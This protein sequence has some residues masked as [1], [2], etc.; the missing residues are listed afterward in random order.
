[1]LE[2]EGKGEIKR[3]LG[4]S[5]DSPDNTDDTNN[6]EEPQNQTN[7]SSQ[8]EINNTY[9]EPKQGDDLDEYISQIINENPINEGSNNT[10]VTASVQQSNSWINWKI[11]L[12]VVILII[13]LNSL[14][15]L[16][17]STP[18]TTQ[19]NIENVTQVNENVEKQALPSTKIEPKPQEE[20]AP[21]VVEKLTEP[22]V[23]EPSKKVETVKTVSPPVI[24]NKYSDP[25]V[26]LSHIQNQLQSSFREYGST[27][28]VDCS[29]L[30]EPSGQVKKIKDEWNADIAYNFLSGISYNLPKFTDKQGNKI[31]LVVNF[32]GHSL[33]VKFQYPPKMTIN[34]PKVTNKQNKSSQSD[35]QKS[36]DW[37]FE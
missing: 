24:Q 9:N 2:N 25:N 26:Y 1:M 4:R 15:H 6:S 7:A 8:I 20:K 35:L 11:I 27:A 3:V 14:N 36:Q 32:S 21:T 18:Q 23:K 22:V 5:F 29:M 13:M 12:G 31:P 37:F 16:K 28:S 33:S 30:I 17:Q 19:T 34:T 10:P